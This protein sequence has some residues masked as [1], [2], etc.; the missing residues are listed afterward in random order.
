MLLLDTNILLE[1][2]LDREHA[3]DVEKLLRTAAARTLFVSDF[4]VYSI[5]I[6]LLRRG[7]HDAF[8]KAMDDLVFS[9]VIGLLRAETE[10]FRVVAR[11]S[12]SCK[13][14]FDDSYQRVVADRNNC[15]LV[16]FDSDFD[17]TK[18]GRKTPAEVLSGGV[19][20]AKA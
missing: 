14:D 20:G 4:S 18:N 5:G 10:D 2:L 9:G 19:A 6:I 11:T 16:S 12:K 1:L 13:L 7:L 15:T 8:V 17:R 3:D